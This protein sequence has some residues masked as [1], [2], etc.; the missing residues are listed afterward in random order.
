MAVE[1]FTK[2]CIKCHTSRPL[3]DF[4][5]RNDRKS[6][7][8]RRND[9]KFCCV[10]RCRSWHVENDDR[11]KKYKH[12]WNK[13]NSGEILPKRRKYW[14]ENADR[15]NAAAKKKKEEYRKKNRDACN[16][17]IN[18][19]KRRNK[20]SLAFYSRTRKARLLQAI[21]K[22]ADLDKI[23]QFYVESNRLTKE[24]GVAHHVDHI[25]PLI[26]GGGKV[27]GLHCEQ[28]LRVIT[29]EENL[30]KNGYYWPDMP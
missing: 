7:D 3:T 13:E 10:K 17:R 29:K 1:Q 20:G 24:T 21:P 22:W 23:E 8:R 19:W 2:V 18:D 28:N 25:I 12:R 16:K 6:G 9:C 26:G 11:V 30:K 15:L 14:K 4:Y 27:C 5:Y